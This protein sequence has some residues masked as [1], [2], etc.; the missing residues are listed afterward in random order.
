MKC[1]DDTVDERKVFAMTGE[2]G[3]ELE[4]GG[5]GGVGGGR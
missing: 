1:I 5:V 4:V 3:G 2:T